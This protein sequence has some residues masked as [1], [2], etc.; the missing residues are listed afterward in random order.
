LFVLDRINWSDNDLILTEIIASRIGIELDRQVL[1]RQNDDAIITGER[2]RLTRDLHDSILQSLTA[3][4]LQLQLSAR[5]SGEALRKRLSLVQQI[6]GRE[7]S[8]IRGFVEEMTSK[9]RGLSETMLTRDLESS[10]SNSA[11]QWGCSATL[12]VFPENATIPRHLGSELSLLL[13]EALAN[14]VRHGHAANVEVSL[15]KANGE[16]VI[17]ISDNGRGFPVGA[18]AGLDQTFDQDVGP[19]SLRGRVRALGGS[20]TASNSALGAVLDVRIPT[21]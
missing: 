8:R 21:P 10:L 18:S 5:D 15:A 6:L 20:F 4:G 14:A 3:A 2:M 1:Q 19:A 11:Q 9:K 16:L 7:Q 13:A 17:R 12:S